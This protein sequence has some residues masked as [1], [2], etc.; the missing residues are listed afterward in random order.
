M[1]RMRG[2][3]A[4]QRTMAPPGG[5]S[6]AGKQL[7]SKPNGGR[8]PVHASKEDAFVITSDDEEPQPQASLCSPSQRS[9][10]RAVASKKRVSFRREDGNSRSGIKAGGRSCHHDQVPVDLFVSPLQRILLDLTARGYKV[11]ADEAVVLDDGAELN[12]K[13]IN[14]Y[15]SWL[16]RESH[17]NGLEG[18]IG[19][20]DAE[21][22]ALHALLHQGINGN[23][24]ED[25]EDHAVDDSSAAAQS[26][27]SSPNA[28]LLVGVSSHFLARWRSLWKASL[29]MMSDADIHG[30]T[31]GRLDELR[32]EV[33]RRL[34]SWIGGGCRIG[35]AQDAPQGGERKMCLRHWLALRDLSVSYPNGKRYLGKLSKRKD[36]STASVGGH[37]RKGGHTGNNT[38][39]TS[40]E[41]VLQTAL[42]QQLMNDHYSVMPH[43]CC[44]DC[45]SKC[46]ILFPVHLKAQHH[47]ILVVITIPECP[48]G[49]SPNHDDVAG[50]G[51][52]GGGSS[53]QKRLC[54]IHIYDSMLW[55]HHLYAREY[56]EA[57]YMDDT[58]PASD[59]PSQN[60][61]QKSDAGGK[62]G[63]PRQQREAKDAMKRDYLAD[64]PIDESPEDALP[65][66]LSL[67]GR[68]YRK[69]LW[70]RTVLPLLQAARSV[71]A[72]RVASIL[73]SLEETEL[74]PSRTPVD[75][76]T[77]P[78][79]AGAFGLSRRARHK[80]AGKGVDASSRT[81]GATSQKSQQ[82]NA[83]RRGVRVVKPFHWRIRWHRFTV[84]QQNGVDCGV[85][86]CRAAHLVVSDSLKEQI[87]KRAAPVQHSIRTAGKRGV[88]KRPIAHD[89]PISRTSGR[90]ALGAGFFALAK[91]F[92][93][94]DSILGDRTTALFRKNIFE[95]LFPGKSDL[96]N[97]VEK[98]KDIQ[99]ELQ[100]NGDR[101]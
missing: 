74:A 33:A 71:A 32:G 40:H 54:K 25:G 5:S 69:L 52:G 41:D 44:P 92:R 84:T 95:A 65:N 18:L 89:A 70:R 28:A 98:L 76:D 2:S 97:S 73:K 35:A 46:T 21:S 29:Q 24:E 62:R 17:K 34:S 11:S 88:S 66:P 56:N 96:W 51:G 79:G 3:S 38:N 22:Y 72:A 1:K 58:W 15:T 19:K 45:S 57:A 53:G 12:D 26:L 81:I 63:Q 100:R 60:S 4:P 101:H 49:S 37:G 90:K 43:H 78:G 16:V 48:P 30:V 13:I 59:G 87:K 93:N 55:L 31:A 27:A 14:D 86:V 10:A 39:N 7:R 42:Y 36:S 23:G 75:F 9:A 61:Q 85:A 47:W 91:S 6:S 67:D 8:Q 77:I 20:D 50:G 94:I 99:L 64:L 80:V 83:T 68:Q 82:G